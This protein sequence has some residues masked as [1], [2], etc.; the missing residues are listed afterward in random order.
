MAVGRAA[1]LWLRL[2][3]LQHKQDALL[4]QKKGA[5]PLEAKSYGLRRCS[6][7]TSYAACLQ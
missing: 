5:V 6:A 2:R 1:F 7:D 3:G 4:V